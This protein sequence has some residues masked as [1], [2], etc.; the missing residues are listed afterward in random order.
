MNT[1]FNHL[2]LKNFIYSLYFVLAIWITFLIQQEFPRRLTN[3]GIYPRTMEGLRGIFFSPFLH[4]DISHLYHNS[5]PLFVLCLV[6]FTFY[7]ETSFKVLIYGTLLS[8]LLTWIIGRSSYHIGASGIVYLLFSYVFFSGIIKKHYRLMA[9]SFLVIFLYGSMVWY[10]FPIKAQVSWE[11]HTAGFL[12][13]LF[14]AI[15]YQFKGVVKEPYPY[16]VTEFDSWFDEDGTFN[17]PVV[18]SETEIIEDNSLSKP[19]ITSATSKQTLII[20]YHISSDNMDT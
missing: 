8:G 11:G 3:Y 2:S 1:S 10:L 9:L 17:P 6:L 14:Y 4:G 5:I 15:N 7:K 13:G 16:T 12:V 20:R 18:E 19:Y